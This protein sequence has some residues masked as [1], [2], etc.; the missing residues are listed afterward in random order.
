MKKQT[1]TLHSVDG[2]PHEINPK[3]IVDY[4]DRKDRDGNIIGSWLSTTNHVQGEDS[5]FKETREEILKLIEELPDN[6]EQIINLLIEINHNIKELMDSQF[7][8]SD[9]ITQIR[10]NTSH[11]VELMRT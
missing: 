2:I 6:N 3:Q 7:Y 9:S 8:T 1:I 5:W 10:E 11:I 4:L